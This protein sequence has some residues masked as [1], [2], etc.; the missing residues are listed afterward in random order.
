VCRVKRFTTGWQTF[1]CWRKSL[2]GSA[3]VAETTVRRLLC[4]GFRRTGMAM[5]QVYQSWWRICGEINV[6][7]RFEY[8]I[9]LCFI[10]MCYLFTDSS[11]YYTDEGCSGRRK[12]KN[13]EI[14]SLECSP[15]VIKWSRQG[16][17]EDQDT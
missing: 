7:S 11:L 1:R 8:H 6:F 12:L 13:E 10:S 4:C 14:R 2:N 9:F 16:T 3:E 15:S 5:G 17:W